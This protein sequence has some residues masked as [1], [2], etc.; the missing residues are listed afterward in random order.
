MLDMAFADRGKPRALHRLGIAMHVYADTWSHQGFAG[1]LHEVNEVEH[2]IDTGKSKVF[3]KNDLSG[4]L[5]GVLD[6]TLPPL[7]HGRANIFPDMPF[8]SWQYDNGMGVTLKRNNTELFCKAADSMCRQMQRYR[9]VPETGIAPGEMAKIEALFTGLKI[10]SGDERH[11]A[12]LK[13]IK[14]GHFAFGPAELFYAARGKDSWKAAALG[15][16]SDLPVHTYKDSF[17]A[18]N[19][20]LFHDALQQHRLSVLHD[21]LP[22][23]GICAA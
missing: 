19:W 5:R 22:N 13:Q 4:W 14:T 2:A 10:E 3:K 18:S 11:E 15:T 8:L 23:Y 16:S 9:G 17:L 6:D 12:W 21:I 1:V 20:K 7:G